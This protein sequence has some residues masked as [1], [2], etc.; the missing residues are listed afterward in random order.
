MPLDSKQ[1]NRS[2]HTASHTI[3]PHIVFFPIVTLTLILWV[4]YRSVFAFPVW[5]DEI[6]GKALFFGIPVWLYIAVTQTSVITDAIA[7][8]KLY[9]GILQGIAIGGIFGF[10]T[11]LFSLAVNETG[12]QTALLFE[13]QAFWFEFMLA[14]FTAFWETIFFFC[15]VMGIIQ[16]KFKN[17]TLT[18]QVVLAA[19][20]FLLFHIPNSFLRF[21]PAA[22]VMQ[23]G[24]LFLFAIGQALLFST[25]RNG[26]VLILSHAIWGMVLL[27]HAGTL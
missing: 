10:A 8:K 18:K 27:T 13:S 11:S 4:V 1:T 2:A 12:V 16:E 7:P 15:F 24:L 26:Y 21:D 17:W 23:M 5:F 14:L 20:I 9:V 6:L 3:D 25:K 22:A 19:V